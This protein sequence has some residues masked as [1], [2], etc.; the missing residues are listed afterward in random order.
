LTPTRALRAAL[1][2]AALVAACTRVG[3][4]PA[5]A[6]PRAGPRDGPIG[7]PIP[8]TPAEAI[9]APTPTPPPARPAGAS[10][11][12]ARFAE[13]RGLWVVRF[14]L[15]SEASTRAVVERAARAGFNTLLVQVRGRGDAYYASRLEPRG[16]A[17]TGG[18]GFDPLALIVE[19]AHARGMAVHAWMNVSLVAD[20]TT[21]PSDPDHIAHAHPEA[22]MLP[23]ALAREL[24]GVRPSDARYARRLIA[25][26]RDN[27]SRVEGLYA[28]PAHPAVRE[29]TVAVA[30]DL[31]KR[32]DL[33]GIH[34]D[35]IRYPGPDFDYSAG[36]VAAFR[37][38]AAPRVQPDKRRALD[39]AVRSNPL[40]WPDSLP[41]EW[42]DFRREQVTTLLE[43]A[44]VAVKTV[45]PWL[46]V[47]AAVHPDP[48]EAR[49]GRMQDWPGWVRA[50]LLRRGR[51]DG[52]HGRPP[53]LRRAA[54]PRA[55][56][57]ALDRDLGRDRVLPRRGTG[58]GGAA[59]GRPRARHAR[60]H[61]VFVRL[62]RECG[63][64]RRRSVPRPR[65]AQPAGA[66]TGQGPHPTFRRL[67]TRDAPR[68]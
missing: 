53:R 8:D 50:G 2:A 30:V 32:Y 3:T 44:Y 35:Y 64:R 52:V 20:A 43:R 54:R 58:D 25:W 42:G 37:E 12:P 10:R 36:T 6:V 29:R 57:G 62:G 23:R 59:R 33:D 22:L 4:T 61:A 21:I 46:I 49:R 14:S 38:W 27:L 28:S 51:A 67:S 31:A 41:A 34:F 17:I 7:T 40:A 45:R 18:P 16:S 39:R 47:S 56:G 15:A 5:P 1:A 63:G 19:Q 13:V 48:N 60:R 55:R 24:A 9:P 66:L 65:R 68:R 26:T 11:A